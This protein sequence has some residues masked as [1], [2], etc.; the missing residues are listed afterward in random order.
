LGQLGE[1]SFKRTER[2]MFSEDDKPH[3]EHEMSRNN[4]RKFSIGVAIVFAVVILLDLVG[5]S[6][7]HNWAGNPDPET[8]VALN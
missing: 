3:P 7:T 2:A 4:Q 8:V 1:Y 5:G 6:P